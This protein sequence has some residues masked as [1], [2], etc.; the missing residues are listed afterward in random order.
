V[1]GWVSIYRNEINNVPNAIGDTGF[2]K[3]F[4]RWQMFIC[5]DNLF[6]NQTTCSREEY[7]VFLDVFHVCS[8]SNISPCSNLYQVLR[9]LIRC[10]HWCSGLSN[11]LFRLVFLASVECKHGFSHAS[12]KESFK[13]VLGEQGNGPVRPVHRSGSW[14]SRN[15]SIARWQ[16]NSQTLRNVAVTSSPKYSDGWLRWLHRHSL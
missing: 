4:D 1:G 12:T 6:L 16:L 9:M 3:K 10:I 8:S 11:A 7:R 5:E 15:Y 2:I 14:S 13:W